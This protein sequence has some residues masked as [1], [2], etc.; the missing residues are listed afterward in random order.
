MSV[1]VA[2]RLHLAVTEVAYKSISYRRRP[3]GKEEVQHY[4]EVTVPPSAAPR[5]RRS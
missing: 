4:Y 3:G 1:L 5:L 2:C